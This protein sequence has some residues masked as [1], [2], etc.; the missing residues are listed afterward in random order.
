M[1]YQDLRPQDWDEMVGNRS[2]VKS[3]KKLFESNN[4][5]HAYLFSGPSGCGK[6]TLARILASKVECHPTEF[7]EI[8]AANSRGIDTIREIAAKSTIPPLYGKS[9]VVLLDECGQQTSQAQNSML[10]ML[11]DIPKHQYY[12]LCT[13]E[14]ERVL[15]TIKTRCASYTVRKLRGADMELLIDSI[16]GALDMEMPTEL[17]EAIAMA[18]EGCPRQAL[19]LIEQVQGLKPEEALEMA[20]NYSGFQ[21]DVLDLCR[22]LTNFQQKGKFQRVLKLLKSIEMEPE[23]VKRALLGYLNKVLLNCKTEK[24]AQHYLGIIASIA[25]ARTYDAGEVGLNFSVISAIFV[26]NDVII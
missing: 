12:I 22:E 6:T 8:N 2:V 16:A 18:A 15:T 10:K 13:T 7:W 14:P 5:P 17:R 11:E 3:L 4:H 25:Q 20:E 1:L 9:R 21:A 23:R 26:E 19:V 24:Q